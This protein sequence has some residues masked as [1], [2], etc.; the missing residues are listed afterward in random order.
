MH[1]SEFGCWVEIGEKHMWIG[2]VWKHFVCYNWI[3]KHYNFHLSLIRLPFPLHHPHFPHKYTQYKDIRPFKILITNKTINQE[4]QEHSG[5]F[6][7]DGPSREVTVRAAGR[8]A[9]AGI[10]EHG[11]EGVGRVADHGLQ[12]KAVLREGWDGQRAFPAGS[13]RKPRARETRACGGWGK[14][15]RLS[16]KYLGLERPAHLKI[17]PYPSIT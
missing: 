9:G 5:Q 6:L 7:P 17:H 16:A 1:L 14:R 12:V 8:R 2:L 3:E 15:W 4:L 11:D 10:V 13:R